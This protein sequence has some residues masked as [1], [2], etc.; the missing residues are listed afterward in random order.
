MYIGDSLGRRTIYSPEKLAIVDVGR[1][2]E[3]RLTFRDW[4]QRVTRFANWLKDKVGIVKGDRVAI[5]A[6]DGI[7]H[8]DC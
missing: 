7:E 5:F 4:N 3:L 6:R 8:L 1:E 2:P